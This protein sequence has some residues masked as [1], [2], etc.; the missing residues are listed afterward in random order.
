MGVVQM[1]GKAALPQ[2]QGT[3]QAPQ[4]PQVHR[5][6][7]TLAACQPRCTGDHPGTTAKIHPKC[8]T[9]EREKNSFHTDCR[10]SRGCDLKPGR[11]GGPTRDDTASGSGFSPECIRR[12][13]QGHLK[14]LRVMGPWCS[15]VRVFVCWFQTNHLTLHASPLSK[16]ARIRLGFVVTMR[17]CWRSSML[18]WVPG[19]AGHR[20]PIGQPRIDEVRSSG[21]L[22][23]RV[24]L[25]ICTRPLLG[26]FSL[27]SPSAH[28]PDE[29]WPTRLTDPK[30]NSALTSQRRSALPSHCHSAKDG[31]ASLKDQDGFL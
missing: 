7:S 15:C 16:F 19:K 14:V 24:P 3:S 8:S 6:L 17:C 23:P 10:F 1:S 26:S 22:C 27:L 20:S 4:L 21:G 5:C 18:L 11:A 13:M 29:S 28:L 12:L 31:L 9:E 2:R 25:Q 30:S